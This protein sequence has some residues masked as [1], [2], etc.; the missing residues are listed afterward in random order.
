[1]NSK[2]VIIKIRE[3]IMTLKNQMCYADHVSIL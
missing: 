2:K 1:M 3:E